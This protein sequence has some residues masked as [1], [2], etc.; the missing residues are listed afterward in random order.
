VTWVAAA[1]YPDFGALF[2]DTRISYGQGGS[3]VE[4]KEFGVQKIHPVAPNLVIGFAGTI[5]DGFKLVD[6]LQSYVGALPQAP[7]EPR[8]IAEGWFESLMDEDLF[9]SRCRMLLVGLSPTLMKTPDDHVLPWHAPYGVRFEFGDKPAMARV[10]LH[11]SIGSGSAVPDYVRAIEDFATNAMR[12]LLRFERERERIALTMLSLIFAQCVQ[13][14]P[15]AGVNAYFVGAILSVNGLVMQT[16]EGLRVGQDLVDVG[17]IPLATDTATFEDLW[18]NHLANTTEIVGLEGQ[19]VGYG[20]LEPPTSALDRP[21]RLSREF[22]I[23][24]DVTWRYQLSLPKDVP[25]VT[26]LVKRA[27]PGPAGGKLASC[28]P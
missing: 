2:G 11:D 4:V 26:E 3:L 14:T 1:L 12:R 19:M 28:R 25:E 13:R 16:N 15:T 27:Q 22:A 23:A 8:T 7:H 5:V 17:A 21:E 6:S 24:N 9:H 20:G 10:P 18:N